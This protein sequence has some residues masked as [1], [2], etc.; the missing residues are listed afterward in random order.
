MS[1]IKNGGLDQYGVEPFERQQF[2]AASVEGAKYASPACRSGMC[3]AADHDSLLRRIKRL[4]YYSDDLYP[5][6]P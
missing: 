6:L 3:S 2:G 1:K 5:S 4:G